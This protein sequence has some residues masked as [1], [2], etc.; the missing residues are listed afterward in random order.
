MNALKRA[1]KA[2]EKKLD[3]AIRKYQQ[4]P[5]VALNQEIEQLK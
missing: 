1:Y 2:A 4:N 3:L 5:T